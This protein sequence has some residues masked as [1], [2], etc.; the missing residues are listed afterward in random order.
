M[1]EDFAG[2]LVRLVLIVITDVASSPPRPSLSL[3]NG[4]W[5]S[6]GFCAV[7]FIPVIVLSVITSNFYLKKKN[8][9]EDPADP[10]GYSGYDE[11]P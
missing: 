10:G 1:C 9:E 4:F 6:L 8:D 2:G 3:Q 7:L 11:Y 5:W